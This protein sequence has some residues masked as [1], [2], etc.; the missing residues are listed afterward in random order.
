MRITLGV[1]D[2]IANSV[3]DLARARG[4]SRDTRV[5]SALRACY[6]P[7]SSELRAELDQWQAAADEDAAKLG[8]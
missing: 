6:P 5:A 1:P 7:M 3:E 8:L 2:E 4:V